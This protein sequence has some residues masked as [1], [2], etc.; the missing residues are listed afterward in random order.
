MCVC[1][2]GGG[3]GGGYICVSYIFYWNV[4][5]GGGGGV[6]GDRLRRVSLLLNCSS[7]VLQTGENT[8]SRTI[9]SKKLAHTSTHHQ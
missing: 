9:T 7:E 1:V 4:K 5:Q 8:T 3:G 6:V 2:A